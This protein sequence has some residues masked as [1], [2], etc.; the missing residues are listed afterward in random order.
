MLE[1]VLLFKSF[2][3]EKTASETG[4]LSRTKVLEKKEK[5]YRTLHEVKKEVE[6]DALAVKQNKVLTNFF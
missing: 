5:R 4:C 1:T 2:S 6:E 3:F